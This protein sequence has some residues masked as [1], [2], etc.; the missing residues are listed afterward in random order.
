MPAVVPEASTPAAKTKASAGSTFEYGYDAQH[1]KA[2]RRVIQGPKK[3]GP[4]EWSFPATRDAQK[5]LHD[6]VVFFF[7]DGDKFEPGTVTQDAC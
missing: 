2:W 1:G 3:K 4:I 6:P 5:G 7:S